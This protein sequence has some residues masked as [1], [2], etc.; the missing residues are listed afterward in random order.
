[1]KNILIVGAGFSGAVIARELAEYGFAI[2]IIDKRNHIGGNA[3]DSINEFGIR[4]HK[5][6]PHLF[7]TNNEKVFSW[8][9]QY[10]EWVEYKHKVK[11]ML[12]DGRLVT[13][14]INNETTEIVGKHNLVD[15][16]IR[17]YS[18]KM[19]GMK[20]EE[21][22]PQ[23]LNR[24][25]MRNDNNEFY[26][27]DDQFQFMPKHGYFSL[28]ENILNHS[29][30]KLILNT[31]F[32]PEMQKEFD[33]T[34]NSMAI[35]EFFDYSLGYLPYR[36]I[37]FTNVNLPAPRIFPVSV[38]NFTHEGKHTRVVE[39]KNIP[40]QYETTDQITTL[41]YEEPCDYRENDMERYYPVK[42]IKGENR[43]LYEEYKKRVPEN[44]EF[45]GRLG[46]YA[47]LDMHQCVNNALAVS[48]KFINKW[49]N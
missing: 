11:A 42:D 28:F 10:T 5:Y 14:P 23:I 24:V 31:P 4:V 34:F 12:K 38:V 49:K 36:S 13:L 1:M 46:L 47:Y 22:D 41:T 33:F 39:W 9:S 32:G 45:I 8:L 15:T 20:L 17:P 3:F 7:H 48:M 37:K 35:D 29:N 25:P 40:N 30:I 21:L 44:M 26:F 6:G 19:W 27:P 18:E 16:F 43:K 2:T